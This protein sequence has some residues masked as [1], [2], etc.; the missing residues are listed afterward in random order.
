MYGNPWFRLLRREV[1]ALVGSKSGQ[2][3][4]QKNRLQKELADVNKEARKRSVVLF[5]DWHEKDTGRAGS[6]LCKLDPRKTDA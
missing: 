5:C 2:A 4:P 3:R 6:W 1:D